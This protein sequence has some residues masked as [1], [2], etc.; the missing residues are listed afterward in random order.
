MFAKLYA[1][2][3]PVFFAIDMLW[4]GLVAK[5]FY[6]NQIGFLMK[7]EINWGAAILFYLV[8]IV[9]LVLFVIAPALEKDSWTHA[10]IFGALFGFITYATYDLTNLATLKDW[11]LLV[12][13]VDLAWGTALGTLVSLI[14]YFIAGKVW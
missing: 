7:S 8:F 13:V 10:V 5:N 2:A 12:T 4:L 1:I 9:G 11:P 3:L 6:K 14:S